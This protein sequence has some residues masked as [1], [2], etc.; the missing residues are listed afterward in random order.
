[1]PRTNVTYE[2]YI[3]Q[4]TTQDGRSFDVF[5]TELRH[6]AILCEFGYIK[7]SLIR[8]LQIVI[9]TTNPVLRERLLRKP[10][11]TLAKAINLFRAS[12]QAIEQS[13]LITK[14]EGL[15]ENEVDSVQV[16]AG[17]SRHNN[18][19]LI[20]CR[21]CGLQ[22]DKDVTVRRTTQPATAAKKNT[23]SP[24]V[25]QRSCLRLS[26]QPPSPYAGLRYNKIHSTTAPKRCAKT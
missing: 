19:S 1:M 8:D 16:H 22:N 14:P 23:I 24:A 7:D 17:Q 10:N 21:F 25:A 3:F 18:K 12:E 2:R 13:K 11:L 26:A 20:N 5:L 4:T 15:Q 6:K 9:G